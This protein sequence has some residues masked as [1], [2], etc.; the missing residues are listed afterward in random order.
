MGKGE[1]VGSPPLKSTSARD[2]ST[3]KRKF[4]LSLRVGIFSRARTKPIFQD[5]CVK[6]RRGTGV[7]VIV[8]LGGWREERPLGTS[9]ENWR[10]AISPLGCR[11]PCFR[12][13]GDYGAV[14]STL[15]DEGK[16]KGGNV[17]FSPSESTAIPYFVYT[18]NAQPLLKDTEKHTA[19]VLPV[20]SVSS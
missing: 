19:S 11:T 3:L 15:L 5:A 20:F 7:L 4:F 10:L 2:V 16:Q 17:E 12:S 9:M 6:D 18:V 8:T 14:T 1:G 13:E